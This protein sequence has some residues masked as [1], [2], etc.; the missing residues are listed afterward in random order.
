VT[1]I[2]GIAIGMMQAHIDAQIDI[3]ILWVPPARIDD[4]ICVCRGINRTV[5]D[6]IIHAVVAIIKHPIAKAVR[7][8]SSAPCITNSGL[9][10]RGARGWRRRTVLVCYIA[11]ECEHAIIE[12]VVRRGMIEDRFL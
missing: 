7:P 10:R 4:L 9:G 6:A 12:C 3:V 1:V 8:V 5:S 11:C 2:S